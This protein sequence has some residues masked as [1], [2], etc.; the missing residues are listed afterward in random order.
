MYGVRVTTA[1]DDRSSA[2]FMTNETELHASFATKTAG[3]HVMLVLT[4][5]AVLIGNSIGFGKDAQSPLIRC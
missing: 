4:G 3:P 2:H 1:A 5:G